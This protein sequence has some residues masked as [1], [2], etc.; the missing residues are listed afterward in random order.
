MV[1]F[2]NQNEAVSW[3]TSRG[4]AFSVTFAARTA[5]RAV[6]FLSPMANRQ[7]NLG[8]ERTLETV[9]AFFRCSVT[10]LSS[11][12]YSDQADFLETYSL[13]ASLSPHI[14]DVLGRL[15]HRALSGAC[16]S[17]RSAAI[18]ASYS[19]GSP[20]FS[21]RSAYEAIVSSVLY[22]PSASAIIQDEILVES[23][24]SSEEVASTKAWAESSSSA[25]INNFPGEFNRLW[26]SLKSFL[27]AQNQDWDV[28]TRWY[29]ARV[30]GE[31]SNKDLDLAIATIPNEDWEQGPAHVN[32][33]I[34]AL[35][36]KY[37]PKAAHLGKPVTLQEILSIASP[38]IALN[39]SG[40]IDAI[41]NPRF[42]R[43]IVQQDD[44][45]KASNSLRK[46]ID[47]TLAALPKNAPPA[48][49]R[50][51]EIYNQELTENP[52]AP[53]LGDIV[54]FHDIIHAGLN[55]PDAE[56]EWLTASL[57]LSFEKYF[58]RHA[59]FL[60]MFSSN[61]EKFEIL[62]RLEVDQAKLDLEA[63]NKRLRGLNEAVLNL[64]PQRIFTQR[65]EDELKILQLEGEQLQSG[66]R[67]VYSDEWLRLVKSLL[68]RAY[69]TYYSAG[70]ECKRVAAIGVISVAVLRGL[71]FVGV[72][73]LV[74]SWL[75]NVTK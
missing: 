54:D 23:G 57:Y 68:A 59:A 13:A 38:T 47:V 67:A 8:D 19:A 12:K 35:E 74:L 58:L 62:A 41:P 69:A 42:D 49:R 51:F 64:R 75:L 11:S 9:L 66:Q 10:S 20:A 34:K 6:P 17:A 27:L 21:A 2:S 60:A 71:D 72:K 45:L 61:D 16:V 63:F 55:E 32:A 53:I 15:K 7:S 39:V 1:D 56:R 40:Q 36:D 18:A 46:I 50:S 14:T 25:R 30:N 48:L 43:P 26:Q 70:E 73:Q 33:L 22:P 24:N 29:E 44:L 3:F 4:R 37:A 5:L 31:P 28:W 65:F 52:T